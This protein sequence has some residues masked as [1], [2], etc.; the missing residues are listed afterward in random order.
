MLR[1]A[2]NKNEKGRLSCRVQAAPQPGFIWSHN[3]N[4]LNVTHSTKYTVENRKIDSLTYE[5]TLVVDNVE[6]IDYG[7]YECRAEN[8]LGF[9]KENIRLD[10]TSKPDPPLD[11][12]VLNTT[13]DSVTLAW[14][15]GFDG[16]LKA[17]YRLRY[18]EASSDIYKFED[19]MPNSLKHTIAGL[20][21]NTMYLFSVMAFNTLGNSQYLSDLTK[22]STKGKWLKIYCLKIFRVHGV[23]NCP[24]LLNI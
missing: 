1:A 5:S 24:L 14:T 16:G 17:K 11:L 10:I 4:V 6:T 13:H 7:Q 2:S 18:R 21:K 15:P 22:A 3:S 20:K 23:N 12:I 9:S 19:S 8:E